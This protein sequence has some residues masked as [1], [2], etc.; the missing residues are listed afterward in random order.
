MGGGMGAGMGGGMGSRG[1]MPSRNAPS[2][3][4]HSTV[5]APAPSVGYFG[6]GYPAPMVYGG[7]GG[8]GSALFTFLILGIFAF[9]LFN[10][11]AG[12]NSDE[13]YEEDAD[14]GR[15]PM[16][17]VKLQVGLLG[18]ARDLQ[19]DLN[20]LANNLDTSTPQG[21]H[22][23]LT[24]TV[25]ALQ[26]NPQYAVYGAHR[27]AVFVC[28]CIC[29]VVLHFGRQFVRMLILPA[30]LY[31]TDVRICTLVLQSARLSALRWASVTIRPL[32]GLVHTGW[33]A[34]WAACARALTNDALCCYRQVGARE[35]PGAR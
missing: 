32:D 2:V 13:G 24:E 17:V 22:Y 27:P 15:E 5:L 18:S 9:V 26:R 29:Y 21:L 30:R 14:V 8:G 34:I 19:K 35:D 28:V 7:G 31:Q 16:S 1:A 3:H 11:F 12:G 10:T 20:R 23:L 25:L 33:Q 4:H 6:Y